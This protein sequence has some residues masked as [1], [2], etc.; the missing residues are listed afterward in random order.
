MTA[1][2]LADHLL[3]QAVPAAAVAALALSGVLGWWATHSFGT[4]NRSLPG[5]VGAFLLRSAAGFVA[6]LL[7]AEALERYL[8]LGTRWPLWTLA[9]AAA[10]AVE[11]ALRLYRLE[12]EVAGPRAGRALAAL[13]TG[14]LLLAAAMLLQ[15]T[16]V[17]RSERQM[18]RTV[19]VLVDTSGSMRVADTQMSPPERLRLA[20]AL[21]PQPFPR[22]VALE[23]TAD[24]LARC[25]ERLTTHAEWLQMLGGL[26]PSAAQEHMAARRADLRDAL[27]AASETVSG[28][29]DELEAAPEGDEV[30]E[31]AGAAL[32]DLHDRLA[33]EVRTPLRRAAQMVE[34][35]SPDQPAAHG[36]LSGLLGRALESL[37]SL[38]AQFRRRGREVD[39]AVYAALPEEERAL[40]D[41]FARRTRL[42]VVR[43]L[44]SRSDPATGTEA[45]LLA[46]L[47]A[48]YE[49]RFATFSS[50]ATDADPE[51]WLAATDADPGTGTNLAAALRKVARDVEPG[52]LAGV[53]L[54][55]DGRHNADARVEDALRPL[56]EGEVPVASVVLG[57]DRPPRDAAVVSLSAPD[58][59]HAE[60]TMQVAVD[61]KL[62]GL[63][64]ETAEV[65][66]LREDAEEPVATGTVRI[67]GPRHRARVELSHTPGEAGL[68]SYHVAVGPF[69]GEVLTGNNQSAL[70]VSVTDERT[71]M[72]LL[73][74]RP[75][76][77]FRY[78][79]N[80][81][82]NRDPSV[83][84]QYVL[85]HPD[86]IAGAEPP[87]E[88]PASASRP[89]EE[90]QATRPPEGEAEWM[91]FDV[92]VLGDLSPETLTP[93]ETETIARFVTDRGGTLVAVAGPRCMPHRWASTPLR[94][95]LPVVVRPRQE[96]LLDPVEG[97]FR[98][99]LTAEGRRHVITSQSVDP[100]RNAEIWRSFPPLRWRDP[101]P[102][103]PGAAV[104]AYA[105]PE[106]DS[107][108]VKP[109]SRPLVSLHRVGLGRVVMLSFD[110][111][112]RLRYRAG[113]TH[114]HKFWAQIMRWATRGKLSGG[115]NL[116][117][118]GSERARYR[119]GEKVKVRARMLRRDLSPVANA[120]A[121]VVLY[122]G[123]KRVLRRSLQYAP[124]TP[125]LY[126]AE[127]GALPPGDYRA[128]LHC[129]RAEKL[130][131]AEGAET[132]AAEF[133]VDPAIPPEQAELAPDRGRLNHLAQATGG[134]VAGP[135]RAERVLESLKAGT[136]VRTERYEYVLWNSWPFVGAIVAAAATEWLLRRRS[137]LP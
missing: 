102:A 120:E 108:E 45:G 25:R 95:L 124:E 115:S 12:R 131:E 136:H 125:G 119:A 35:A 78:L 93:G 73:E 6:L 121:A 103:K 65:R 55:T 11:A 101:A 39:A 17:H 94:D 123:G 82:A 16:F 40:A 51:T 38:A 36:E 5:E 116:V 27:A 128:E 107:E 104:L 77:E 109:Q 97:G 60:D 91:Q 67:P 118:L 88:V 126:E 14:L 72:L 61:L 134:A 7:A 48:D 47:G 89:P 13:R 10:V 81:F 21:A 66:L 75:R 80:L 34:S 71:K 133:A 111:T 58:M 4:T 106:E 33:A 122:R 68:Q 130:L 20:G 98:V 113:D 23:R 46:A 50:E 15:A 3:P 99:A 117:K 79:K 37:E 57:A 69:E 44:L 100:E 18:R 59:V 29:A 8:V 32:K 64:G 54:L 85:L 22:P 74:E 56:A 62:D 90:A 1:T 127:L 110:R 129:P 26:E 53:V 137:G 52:R 43:R 92:L 49:V 114:H 112:W 84:L 30:P 19:A 63:A 83:K 9:L 28:L 87:A 41:S 96:P 132:V 76:W 31:E 105:E 2:L 86:H 24:R 42:E 70:T 135:E